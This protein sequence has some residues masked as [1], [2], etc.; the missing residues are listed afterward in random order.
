LDLYK[1][2]HLDGMHPQV[3][4][5]V[6]DRISRSL[7][8]ICEWPWQLGKVPDNWRKANVTPVIKVEK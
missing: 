3:L 4:R 8:I 1:S 7:S 2:I 6:A 5:D